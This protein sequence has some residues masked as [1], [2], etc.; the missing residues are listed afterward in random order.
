MWIKFLAVVLTDSHHGWRFVIEKLNIR[1]RELS[2]LFLS[3]L[4]A[5]L[6]CS[7]NDRYLNFDNAYNY[8]ARFSQ[9]VKIV[10]TRHECRRI[11]S[12]GRGPPC[13]NYLHCCF[14][15]KPARK[16]GR[17]TETNGKTIPMTRRYA[18]APRDQCGSAFNISDRQDFR[19]LLE[20]WMNLTIR[21]DEGL[22]WTSRL[23]IF[24]NVTNLISPHDKSHRKKPLTPLSDFEDFH[25]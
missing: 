21:F 18:A 14:S 8:G 9:L 20:N 11:E 23:R 4:H 13:K 25:R 5:V 17:K 15:Q 3:Q 1:R 2:I 7:Y 19:C 22:F 24:R 16:M 12:P 6:E 10:Q